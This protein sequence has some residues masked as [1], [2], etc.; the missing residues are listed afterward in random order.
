[1]G[2]SWVVKDPDGIVVEEYSRWE[3]F[4]TAPGDEQEFIGGRFDLDKPETYTLNAVLMMN[5]DN[6]V[7]VDSYDGDLCV[8]TTEPPPTYE[9]LEETIYPYAYVY[10]GPH[11][12]GVFNFKSDPFTPASWI[13]GNFAAICEGEVLRT[14]GQVLETRV[15]V[16]KTPLL[17]A[18]WRIE[19]IGISPEGTAGTAISVGIAFWVA[20]LLV[21]LG[22]IGLIV[23][24]TWAWKQTLGK[25]EHKALSEEIKATWSRATLIRII[26][27]FE[28]KLIEAGKIPGPPTPPEELEKMSDEELREYCDQL[29]EWIVPPPSPWG[30]VALVGGVGILGVVAAAAFAMAK[31]KEAARLP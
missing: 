4:A 14:G 28:T 7:V 17:W 20:I 15:Y 16:D 8:V 31:P 2:V 27:D 30:I 24:A 3:M 9:L 11:D 18:N 13:A 1:M 29:A 5:P 12:G 25:Y 23:A 6:P 22:L 10:D 26:G 19:I 21:I